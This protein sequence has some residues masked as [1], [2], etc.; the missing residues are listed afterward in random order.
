M[1][2]SIS[3]ANARQTFDRPIGDFQGVSFKIAGMQA[4]LMA[5]R[6]VTHDG[7][8]LMDA[9][10]SSAMKASVAKLLAS[11]AAVAAA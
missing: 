9:G 10:L 5:A 11:E 3:Y 2:E 4:S 1:E 6:A 7:A 8:D